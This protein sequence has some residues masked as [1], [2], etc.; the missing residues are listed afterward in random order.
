M[1]ANSHGITAKEVPQYP[2]LGTF[3]NWRRRRVQVRE[4]DETHVLTVGIPFDA[5]EPVICVEPRDVYQRQ[6]IHDDWSDYN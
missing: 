2:L 4:F 6:L 3:N 1:M 5:S